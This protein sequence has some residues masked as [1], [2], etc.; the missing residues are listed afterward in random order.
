MIKKLIYLLSS[1]VLILMLATVALV[2][3]INPNDFKPVITEQVKKITGRD[4][5][6]EGEINW[7]FWPEL[8]L[9]IEQVA[10][11][12]PTGFAEKNLLQFNK[13]ELAVGVLPLL[14]QVIDVKSLRLYDAR[15]FMQTLSNGNS[16]LTDL[17]A[18]KTTT[19]TS[20]HNEITATNPKSQT[21]QQ[22]ANTWQV[23]IGEIDVQKASA[24]IRDDKT[25]TI[26][27]ISQLNLLI[28]QLSLAHWSP[29]SF[30]LAGQQNSLSF[31]LQGNAELEL[32]ADVTMSQLRNLS[33]Q[34]KL[35]DESQHIAIDEL[36]L[37]ADQLGVAIPSALALNVT[38]NSQ[39]LAFVSQ[40]KLV[41]EMTKD[42]ELLH[43]SS[44]KLNADLTGKA[45]PKPAMKVGFTGNLSLDKQKKQ[46]NAEEIAF[47]LDGTDV[48]GS[49]NIMLAD[50]PKV[51][52]NLS[53][54]QINLDTLLGLNKKAD[55][56]DTSSASQSTATEPT[57]APTKLSNVEPD[58]SGLNQLDIAGD[59]KVA[60]F[61]ANNVTV[62]DVVA[63][64]SIDRGVAEL[65]QFDAALYQGRITAS[66]KLDARVT[67]ARYEVVKNIQNVNI[68]PL[69]K[70]AANITLLAGRGN[71]KVNLHGVGLSELALRKNL[72]GDISTSLVDGVVYGVNIAYL[73]RE[74]KA[75]L[76][77]EKATTKPAERQTDFSAFQA[78][79]LLAN[80]VA[81][82]KNMLVQ[83]P[84]IR[85]KNQGSTNLLN[86]SMDFTLFA[87]VVETSKGQGS[88][89][90]A[91]LKGLTVPVSIEGTWRQPSYALDVKSLLSSN[92]ILESKVQKEAS[93]L[94][95]KAA[96]EVDRFF[97]G[98]PEDDP[99]KKATKDLLNNLFN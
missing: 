88:D 1:F 3:F 60:R 48:R 77:G 55:E 42:L 96:K 28:E 43:A 21:Q 25:N 5:H 36:K 85:I 67:P 94:H 80:G 26:S 76:K 81:T 63:K 46:I 52:F 24:V 54:N 16:N 9:S 65:K 18:A 17:T 92:K 44:I 84:G 32:Q 41:L 93:R 31:S 64:L 83:S 86:E 2:V 91:N 27:E 47:S 75:V 4:L 61:I 57:A 53:S 70:D 62:S 15:F 87:S 29:V 7:R 78:T 99:L 79:F 20:D 66:A 72:A 82:I 73:L 40:A 10:L 35:N 6:I 50:I 39:G 51:R 97:E 59:I 11:A 23:K 68:Q 90:L 12:N 30:S 89:D 71:V 19:T 14:S 37:T 8:G 49:A 22:T 58:L 13:A 45:L 33:L 74:A 98:K 34:A 38:G 69:L 56:N 95:E